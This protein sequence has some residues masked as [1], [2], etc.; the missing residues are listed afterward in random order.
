M[1]KT[2][3]LAKVIRKYVKNNDR[4][5]PERCSGLDLPEAVEEG[6]E[7]NSGNLQIVSLDTHEKALVQRLETNG[8]CHSRVARRNPQGTTTSS[9]TSRH[10]SILNNPTEENNNQV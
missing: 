10:E 4:I 6:R 3:V 5:T 2:T 9:D 8:N 1:S 7:R